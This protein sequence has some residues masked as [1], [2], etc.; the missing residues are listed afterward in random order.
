[1]LPACGTVPACKQEPLFTAQLFVF[2][3]GIQQV[4][5]PLLESGAHL[6][7]HLMGLRRIPPSR[8]D[9]LLEASVQSLCWHLFKAGYA[10]LIRRNRNTRMI[11]PMVAT[12]MLPSS[13]PPDA[14]PNLR[15]R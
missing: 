12:T 13:P 3:D 8:P 2:L 1:M 6:L 15:N 11:A 5:H 10:R 14:M 4:R 9:I 7:S